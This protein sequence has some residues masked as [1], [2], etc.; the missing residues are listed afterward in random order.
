LIQSILP[1]INSKIV[2]L[3]LLI[4]LAALITISLISFIAA[5]N[6]LKERVEDQLISESTGRGAAVRSLIETRI[7]Q[8]NL[9]GTNDIIQNI[10]SQLYQ[11]KT[12]GSSRDIVIYE[13]N[14]QK[15]VESFQQ[16]LGKSAIL[17]NVKVIRIDGKVLMS[18]D[19]SEK[20]RNYSDNF[21]FKRGLAGPF[22]YFDFNNNKRETIV[23]VPIVGSSNNEASIPIGVIIA[24]MDTDTFDQI[25]LNRKG[26]GETGEVY[27]VNQNKKMISESRFIENAAFRQTVDT[28]PVREC[29]EKGKEI[30]AIYNDYRT[31]PIVGFSYC[32][33]DLGLVLL[34]EIDEAEIFGPITQLRNQIIATSIVISAVVVGIAFYVSRTISRP[35]VQLRNVVDRISKG[36]YNYRVDI[37]S[38]DEIGHLAQHFD[39]MRLSVLETNMNLN[40]L[41][42]ER[43]KELTDMTN[44][45]D[46]TAIVLVTDKDGRITKV[47]QKFVEISKY[48]DEELIG[49]NPRILKSGYH[50]PDFFEKMWKTISRGDI[51]EGEIKNK[52]KYGSYYWVKTTI[53]PF[54]DENR[55][56]NQYIAIQNDITS[57]KKIQSELQE[58]LKRDKQS[59]EIIKR[60]VEEL[61][62]T[63][64]ELRRTDKLKEEFL[65]M[66][67]HE[68]KTPLTPII[69]WCGALKT[70]RIL[71]DLTPSQRTAI[72]T[73]E[74]NAVKLE[75]MVSDMLDA[76]KLELNEIKFNIGEFQVDNL[77]SKIKKDFEPLLREKKIQFIIRAEPS[78][79][80]KSDESR[81]LQVLSALLYN[82]IDFVPRQGGRIEITAESKENDNNIIFGVK[83]NGPGIS[84]D[85]QK[86]LFKKFYQVDTSLTRKHGGTGLGL[87]ISKGIVTGLGGNI[88]VETEEGKGSSFYFSLPKN[89]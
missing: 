12:V 8:V 31:I 76:H 4:S 61:K 70:P 2:A 15:E 14:F 39:Q 40:K 89:Y 44:A 37:K 84:K 68:L 73:I 6:L 52:E 85:K 34:A 1:S 27:L 38:S 60:H 24:T 21:K 64:I 71:G 25:L 43:T 46:A 33:K 18:T 42:Q 53:V 87:A 58:A 66:T 36:D 80:L 11:N 28:L 88:W 79:K 17:E 9:L 30:N 55:Q 62:K 77:F 48:C 51:F 3:S 54:L 86:F 16:V 10:V 69:G 83:D 19:P 23:T 22:V 26:L 7:Q 35:I 78:I 49:Q 56:P 81:I 50:S 13:N 20:G 75:K 67:S 82:S 57:L 45:L 47:N 65:S 41:V 72:D 63:N 32:A 5:H 29:F 74:S 59:A